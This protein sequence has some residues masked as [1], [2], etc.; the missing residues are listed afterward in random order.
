[1][2]SNHTSNRRAKKYEMR[3]RNKDC[4]NSQYRL[5]DLKLDIPISTVFRDRGIDRL[6]P[7]IITIILLANFYIIFSYCRNGKGLEFRKSF[8]CGRFRIRLA[9]MMNLHSIQKSQNYKKISLLED[10]SQ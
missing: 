10:C 5:L 1:M 7:I 8:I 6:L 4:Y 2:C 9:E 3:G